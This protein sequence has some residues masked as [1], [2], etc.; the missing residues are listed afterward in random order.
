MKTKRILFVFLALSLLSCNYL[1]QMIATPTAIPTITATATPTATLTPTAT[2]LLPAYIPPQCAASPLA[3]LAPE[4]VSQT[5]SQLGVVD[6]ISKAEQLRIFNKVVDTIE[7]VYI[8]PDYNG[9]DWNEI[10]SRYKAMIEDGQDTE[11]FYTDMQSM[12]GEL[13]DDHSAFITPMEA[14][15][16]DAELKGELKFVGVGIYGFPDFEKHDLIVISTFPG[17][18]AEYAGIQSHDRVLLVD[19]LPITEDGGSRMRGPECSAVQVQV[20]SPGEQPRDVLL[21]RANVDASVPIDARLVSTT[22][23]SKIGYIFIPSFFDE[24][25][26][27]QIEGALKDFGQLDG[28][29]LDVRLNGGGSSTVAYPIISFFAQGRLGNFVGRGESQALKIVPNPIQNS[30]TVPLAVMVS[31]DTVSF[32]EL[33]AGI[34]RDA[35]GAKITGET[36]LGN[37]ELLHGYNFED[38]SVM[39]IA[40]EK[41]FS[42]FSDVDWE[43]TGIVPDVQA[44]A[45]WETFYFDTDPSIAAAVELL[46]HK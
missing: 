27:G 2:P 31:T 23:G 35:R 4:S 19:G 15:Q 25:L 28:L 22:D 26:P 42:A 5:D 9:K 10:K 44:Y 13:G 1:T 14:E 38:G 34:M 7:E 39:W 24:T 40:S 33:F 12:I 29:I 11:S 43:E 6:E 36:S 37:V 46:G 21:Y 32:G 8:Y 30:Q 18:P 45:D 20:Q 3:T 41:F 16:N 17:S